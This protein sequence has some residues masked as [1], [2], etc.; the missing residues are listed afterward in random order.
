[1]EY[2]YLAW[3]FFKIG[4]FGFGGG[5]AMISLIQDEVVN[6]YHWM[7]SQAFADM[8]ALSQ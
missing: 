2:L 3:V 7:N 8:L 5:Y 6:N 1:M 4:L